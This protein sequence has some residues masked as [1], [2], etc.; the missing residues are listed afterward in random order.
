MLEKF[1][2]KNVG[3]IWN[4]QKSLAYN[5]FWNCQIFYSQFIKKFLTQKSGVI[6]TN[7]LKILLTLP[8][9]Y[10]NVDKL[11]NRQEIV[12]YTIVAIVYEWIIR[13][14]TIDK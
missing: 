2:K 12:K 4:S 3:K 9:K 6:K 5:D 1:L 7:L 14:K 11:I 10:R 13:W 8:P